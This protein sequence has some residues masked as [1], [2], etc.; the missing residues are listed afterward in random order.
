MAPNFLK[1]SLSESLVLSSRPLPSV[2][3]HCSSLDQGFYERIRN[4]GKL[5][6]E[7]LAEYLF[8]KPQRVS[9]RIPL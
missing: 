9:Y 7:Y 5:L 6:L 2:R 1:G 3:P 8:C 4:L